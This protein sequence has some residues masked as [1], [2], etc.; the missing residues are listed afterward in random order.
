MVADGVSGYLAAVGDVDAM[1]DAGIRLL[2]DVPHWQR[3]SAAARTAAER[4]SVDRIVP[5]YEAFYEEVLTR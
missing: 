1:A 3:T 4:F 5:L 2:R